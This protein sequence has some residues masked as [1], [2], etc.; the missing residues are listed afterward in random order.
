MPNPNPQTLYFSQDGKTHMDR[1]IR[2]A[3]K[4]LPKDNSTRWSSFEL[5]ISVFLEVREAY[6]LWWEKY[7]TEFAISDK[8]TNEDWDQLRKL[9]EFLKSILDATRF[10]EGNSTTLERV[11]PT[12]EFVLDHFEQGKVSKPLFKFERM[13]LVMSDS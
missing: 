3:G 11:L 13:H 4:R 10:L 12:M 2:L 8:L 9:H 1:W 7:P 6:E 5:M